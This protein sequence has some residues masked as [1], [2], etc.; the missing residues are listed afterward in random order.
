MLKNLL[1]KKPEVVAFFYLWISGKTNYGTWGTA[2]LE[3]FFSC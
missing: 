2:R 3:S 1:K